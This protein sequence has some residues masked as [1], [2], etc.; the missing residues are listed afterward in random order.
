M[1]PIVLRLFAPLL[2]VI[3][4]GSLVACGSGG[5][6]A[7]ARDFT[8]ATDNTRL[9]NTASAKTTVLP[10]G[11]NEPALITAKVAINDNNVLDYLQVALSTVPVMPIEPE[12]LVNNALE[13]LALPAATVK[14]QSQTLDDSQQKKAMQ[15]VAL[16]SAAHSSQASSYNAGNSELTSTINC[17]NSGGTLN[18]QID[19]LLVS[20]IDTEQRRFVN[21]LF[22]Y[23]N[24]ELNNNASGV[25]DGRVSV[26]FE[27]N[28]NDATQ[29]TTIDSDT[30][31]EQVT[32]TQQ[33][34]NAHN[35]ITH[36]L[37]GRFG[38]SRIIKHS[39][40]TKTTMLGGTGRVMY[41]NGQ[42]KDVINFNNFGLVR[43][44]SSLQNITYIYGSVERAKNSQHYKYD[45]TT[46]EPMGQVAG[47][48]QGVIQ[49]AAGQSVLLIR[50][51]SA[52]DY[53]L[54]LD[55]EGDGVIDYATSYTAMPNEFVL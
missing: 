52:Q 43:E 51:V 21:A 50:K 49:V 23:Q 4:I 28:Y 48:M 46:L 1:K 3:C 24:C 7:N 13:A 8:N 2:L 42:Q 12:H 39:N 11:V 38:V 22:D 10:A 40:N 29:E 20:E 36:A 32:F 18:T 14:P 27:R 17:R 55:Y 31:F 26:K 41:L 54:E 5:S 53:L 47:V 25:L 16:P 33:A 19:H 37:E 30:A 44:V 35:K 6:S 34:N 45:V 9:D 15:F